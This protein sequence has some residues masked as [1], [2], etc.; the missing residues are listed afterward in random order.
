ML[1][2]KTLRIDK[3]LS[4]T[5]IC[6]LLNIKQPYASALENGT[7]PISKK[8]IEI[9]R[10]RY[11]ADLD[12]Y[13]I[14]TESTGKGKKPSLKHKANIIPFFRDISLLSNSQKD[15]AVAG[16]IDVGTLFTDATAAMRYYGHNIVEY[17]SGCI[18]LLREVSN[19]CIIHW[20]SIYLVEFAGLRIVAR[21]QR[22]SEKTIIGHSTN[23]DTYI[24]GKPVYE[25]IEIP[26]EKIQRFYLILGYVVK[27]SITNSRIT[28]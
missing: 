4:Q 19:K 9:F 10:A 14:E 25:P 21:L 18:L 17:P 24:D 2:L 12:K 6:D 26:I 3:K 20:G 11:G 15:D 16:Y 23:K 8:H 7:R 27:Q 28:T 13:I 22:G 1:D 5:D